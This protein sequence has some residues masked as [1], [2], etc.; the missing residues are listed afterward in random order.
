MNK[1]LKNVGKIALAVGA[2]TIP[3]VNIVQHAVEALQHGASGDQKLAAVE[4]LV[5]G[6]LSAVE[7][8]A[9]KDLLN[10]AKVKTAYRGFV[11]SYVTFAQALADAKQAR[12]V[13]ANPALPSA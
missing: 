4:D 8:G 2:Q 13:S 10:D 5:L 11:S 3:G 7:F 6:G 1:W 12:A 9:D